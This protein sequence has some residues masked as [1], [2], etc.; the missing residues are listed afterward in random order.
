MKTAEYREIRLKISKRLW[1]IREENGWSQEKF[2]Y[3]VGL[4]RNDIGRIES[5]KS[6]IKL[7]TLIQLASRLNMKLEDF[8]G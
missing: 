6:D 5:G 1:K 2:G 7:G 3:I 8:L 4:H